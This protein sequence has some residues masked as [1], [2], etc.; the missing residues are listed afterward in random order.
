[1]RRAILVAQVNIWRI[2]RLQF[3]L[4]QNEGVLQRYASAEPEGS[5]DQNQN[6]SRIKRTENWQAK[7]NIFTG[8]RGSKA[9]PQITQITQIES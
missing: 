6:V 1:V 7:T 5:T 9:G 4:N 8:V 3:L 2:P